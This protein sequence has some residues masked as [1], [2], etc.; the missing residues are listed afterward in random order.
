MDNQLAIIIE[1]EKDLA[2]V[3]AEALTAANFRPEIYYDGGPALS[4][5]IEVIP[6]L[7][8]LD[9]NLPNITGSEVMELLQ[10]DTRL[11]QVNVIIVTGSPIKAQA[12]KDMADLVL[13]KPISYSQLRDLAKRM[14][15]E[16]Q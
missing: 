6:A 7:V 13:V 3:F 14:Q 10:N 16:Q 8:V 15:S 2:L 11:A 12:H 4:R 5:L 1:D 9:L